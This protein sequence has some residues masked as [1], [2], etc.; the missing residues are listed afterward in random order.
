MVKV[1]NSQPQLLASVAELAEEMDKTVK[2]LAIYMILV[3]YRMF[4][5]THGKVKKILSEEII[6]CYEHNERIM[7]RLRGP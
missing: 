5:E 2:E 4:Q 7:E 1:G 3:V 6:G